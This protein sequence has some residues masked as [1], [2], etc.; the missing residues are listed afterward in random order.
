MYIYIYIIYI[1]IY[2]YTYLYIYIYNSKYIYI[3]IIVNSLKIM[4][5]KGSTILCYIKISK[6]SITITNNLNEYK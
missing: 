3:Y 5:I 2:V 6:I 4:R 1:H